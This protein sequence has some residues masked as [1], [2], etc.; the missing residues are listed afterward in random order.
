LEVDLAQFTIATPYPGT[1]LWDHAVKND[2][3]TTRNWKRFTTLDPVMKLKNFTPSQISRILRFA[4]LKFYL[5]P[6]FVIDDIIRRKGIILK[7]MG[8]HLKNLI[9]A[10]LSAF[11]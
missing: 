1:R 7:K 3:L 6:K 8:E 9:I 2:L 10:K 5:R 4:Y 11:L